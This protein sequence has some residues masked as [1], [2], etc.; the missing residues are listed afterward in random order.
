MCSPPGYESSGFGGLIK[1]KASESGK[2]ITDAG[3][4]CVSSHYQFR[5]LK[6]NLHDRIAYAKELGPETDDRFDLRPAA[7]S[8]HG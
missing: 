1:L 2:I 6:E 7:E 5:E 8:H 3:L 4:R